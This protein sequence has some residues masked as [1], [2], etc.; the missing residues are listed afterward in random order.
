M[1]NQIMKK[2]MTLILAAII[3]ISFIGC[4]SKTANEQKAVTN[5]SVNQVEQQKETTVTTTKEHVEPAPIEIKSIKIKE[6]SI[7][8]PE[9]Y[10]TFKNISDKNIIFDFNVQCLDAYGEV[11]KGYG[12]YDLFSGT[13][14]TPLAPGETSPSD[15]H[16]TLNGFDLT[17][18]VKVSVYKYKLAN[19]EAVRIPH[20]EL[21]WVE[22]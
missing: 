8:V 11:I 14:D 21:H 9:V 6:N 3:T 16:W 4:S 13:Y 19:E 20:D 5:S 22:K 12:S 18:I 2:L 10:I 15:W 17:K 7:G 1:R